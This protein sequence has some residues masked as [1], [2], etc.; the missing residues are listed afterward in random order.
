MEQENRRWKVI[1]AASAATLLFVSATA[2]AQ[3]K[4]GDADGK[5]ASSPQ[6]VSQ[7]T[8]NLPGSQK[9]QDTGSGQSGSP[10]KSADSGNGSTIS[11]TA[12][13]SETG[14]ESKDQSGKKGNTALPEGHPTVGYLMVP[15]AAPESKEWMKKGCWAKFHDGQNFSGDTLTLMGPVDMPD[16]RGPFGIDWKGKISSVEAGAK[17]RILVYDNEN[18]NDLV[19]TFKPGQKSKDVSKKMG[20]FDEFSSLKITCGGT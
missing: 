3:D 13:N 4:R 15:I 16:M 17:A 7:A 6:S 1:A 9:G 10:A 5:G 8:T 14:K 11:S 20:F 2:G 12:G 19:S 18:F